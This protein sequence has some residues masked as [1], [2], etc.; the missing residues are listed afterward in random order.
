MF[1]IRSI[2]IGGTHFWGK[3][4]FYISFP[5]FTAA[6][7]KDE[8]QNYNSGVITGARYLPMG[9]NSKSPRP[10]IGIQWLTPDFSIGDGAVWTK[11]RLGIEAGASMVF[12]KSWTVELTANYILNQNTSYPDSRTSLTT[13]TL[14]NLGVSLGVKK[15]FDFT[16]NIG[17]EQGRQTALNDYTRFEE[18]KAL[19]TW[20]VGAG[21]ST[22]L[23]LS[24]YAFADTLSFLP[25]MPPLSLLPDLALGYYFHKPDLSLRATYRPVVI[26]QS[27]YGYEWESREQRFSLEMIK[28]LFDYKGFVPFAGIGMGTTFTKFL[29]SDQRQ[30]L[31]KANVWDYSYS[32]VFGWDIRPNDAQWYIL[33]TNLRYIFDANTAVSGIKI[34]SDQLEINFIQFVLYPERLKL[35]R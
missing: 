12:K 16:A 19:S 11:S 23:V 6:I 29:S 10:L 22:N 35:L 15:Y 26:G 1:E 33:R 34:S 30:S 5:L 9:L 24:R 3:A 28:F 21:F 18:H 17:S 7:D 27:A 32:L 4:D 20:S 2:T 25:S 13:L 31:T 14:P 8:P